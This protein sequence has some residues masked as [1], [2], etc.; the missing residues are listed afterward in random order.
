MTTEAE[1]ACQWCSIA[2]QLGLLDFDINGATPFSRR[3]GLLHA[4]LSGDSI[5]IGL[6]YDSPARVTRFCHACSPQLLH[7]HRDAEQFAGCLISRQR[8]LRSHAATA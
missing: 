8:Y 2:D 1:L 6:R 3:R 5:R 7:R 4:R